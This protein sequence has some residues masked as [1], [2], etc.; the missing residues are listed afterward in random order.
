MTIAVLAG[1]QSRRMG[2]DKAQLRIDGVSLLE[3]MVHA[4]REATPAVL[5]V[6]RARP[7]DWAG[8]DVPF[9]PDAVPGIGPLGGLATALR[10][11]PEGAPSDAVLLVACDMPKLTAGALR[12]L[13]DAASGHRL[14]HGLVVR[15]GE[16][17]ETLFGI[18][19]WACLPL[20]ERQIA[21]GRRSLQA[22]IEAGQFV[23]IAAPPEIAAALVNVNTP[24]EFE[25]VERA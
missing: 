20:I 7:P 22:L 24:E 9:V 1:G 13:L 14:Q 5:V 11:Q 18:Y 23:R 6:G 3:R 25:G 16:R 12:W 8:D 15:N 10:H 17:I 4:A 2:R 21:S 19:T